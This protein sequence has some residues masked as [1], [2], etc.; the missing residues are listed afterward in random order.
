MSEIF[1]RETLS[2][3]SINQSS[4]KI[5][6]LIRLYDQ[7]MLLRHTESVMVGWLDEQSALYCLIV[8]L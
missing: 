7:L 4:T 2:S 3:Q 8:F 5:E 6:V 1:S